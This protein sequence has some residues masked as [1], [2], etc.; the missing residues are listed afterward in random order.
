MPGCSE[1]PITLPGK[2]SG[3]VRKYSSGELSLSELENNVMKDFLTL[4]I[5]PVDCYLGTTNTE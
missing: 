3:N 1:N 2:E 5:S 4:N